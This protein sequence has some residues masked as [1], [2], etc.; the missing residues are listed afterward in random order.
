[1][2]M[3]Q[4]LISLL[5]PALL[6][7]IPSNAEVVHLRDGADPVDAVRIAFVPGALEVVT[8]AGES[9][10][11]TLDRIARIDDLTDP[12]LI[13]QWR[14]LETA[15]LDVWRARS[16][17][18]RGD[19]ELAR[20]LFRRHFAPRAGDEGDHEFALIIAEGLLRCLLDS[21]DTEAILPAALETLRLRR[22]GIDTDCFQEL[23]SVIDARV[24]LLPQLPPVAT[25]EPSLARLE[26]D[27]RPWLMDS[28]PLVSRLA[29]L[30]AFMGSRSVRPSGSLEPGVVFMEAILGTRSLDGE[31]RRD[32]LQ[33]LAE[34]STVDD[35]PEF[36]DS[37]HA[38]FS[39][40]S[41]LASG[42]VP[43]D[44][45]VLGLLELP[46]VHHG[47]H[48]LLASR[49]VDLSARVLS[50]E[51]RNDESDALKR[52]LL[53]SPRGVP[54]TLTP[55]LLPLNDSRGTASDTTPDL[56]TENE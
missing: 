41:R 2:S 43:T 42:E 39:A 34:L 24:W 33:T 5:L 20:A 56:E 18:Q 19:P 53:E 54:A 52:V 51:G 21:G 36:F 55:R 7:A 12:I 31:L 14:R 3:P 48:P 15:A 47:S 27:L 38:W 8:P 11:F 13:D 22:A 1:M 37:W 16:R 10:R 35:A 17:L 29:E 50:R 45:V 44:R 40:T 46:A 28:D 25:S 9:Q 26:D 30:Y 6:F 4:G 32:S 23:P 49:A